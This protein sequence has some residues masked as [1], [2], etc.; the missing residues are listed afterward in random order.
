MKLKCLSVC[1][2]SIYLKPI[3]IQI[4]TSN[5]SSFIVFLFHI[6]NNLDKQ[7]HNTTTQINL[8]FL[9]NFTQEQTNTSS[10][11]VIQASIMNTMVEALSLLFLAE[12]KCKTLE[13]LVAL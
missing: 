12:N 4:K 3:K 8:F 1:I 5:Y 6:Q 13:V 11:H 2:T 7:Q 10:L 9:P